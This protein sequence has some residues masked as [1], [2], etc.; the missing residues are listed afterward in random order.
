[1]TLLKKSV[2]QEKERKRKE[3]SVLN[4]SLQFDQ[5]GF[6]SEQIEF[7]AAPTKSSSEV[8]MVKM[9]SDAIYFGS[10]EAKMYEEYHV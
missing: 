10:K 6:E 3:M 7:T 5:S 4:P 9:T 1:M 8:P 2:F